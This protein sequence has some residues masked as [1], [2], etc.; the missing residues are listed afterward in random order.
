MTD[1]LLY[2]NKH[3]FDDPA[4]TQ[5]ASAKRVDKGFEMEAM[6]RALAML[7]NRVIPTSA[8]G[9][10][11]TG[12]ALTAGLTA[13]SSVG[14]IKL[15]NTFKYVIDGVMYQY[16][17]GTDIA[18]AGNLGDGTQGTATT[19]Y[20]L[21]SVGTNGTS[22]TALAGNGGPYVTKG[23]EGT[24]GTGVFAFAFNSTPYLPD[25][26]DGQCPVG[27]FSV[28]TK[29]AVPFVPGTSTMGDS[30]NFTIAYGDLVNMPIYLDAEV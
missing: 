26:P 16:T 8:G 20:Y 25:C 5:D 17:G 23:N 27:Y 30:T 13:G 28:I 9:T 3:K 10:T 29:T 6:R 24:S 4:R 22:G 1:T 14:S 21:V 15:A 18:I 2:S 12:Y 7:T 19:C 11:G